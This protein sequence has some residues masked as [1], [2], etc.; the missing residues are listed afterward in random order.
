[1]PCAISSGAVCGN[2]GLAFPFARLRHAIARSRPPP[3]QAFHVRLS[4]PTLPQLKPPTPD[5]RRALS[6]RQLRLGCQDAVDNPNDPT[7]RWITP[8]L[9]DATFAAVCTRQGMLNHASIDMNI[10]VPG[11][12]RASA[13]L[14]RC[15]VAVDGYLQLGNANPPMASGQASGERYGTLLRGAGCH[16]GVGADALFRQMLDAATR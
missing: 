13:E 12:A 5:P 16:Q 8:A 2:I 7:A 3:M 4:L 10:G 11:D 14:L 15:V 1:M 9:I 6:L